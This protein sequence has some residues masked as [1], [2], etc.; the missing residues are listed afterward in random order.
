MRLGFL[1]VSYLNIR[2]FAIHGSLT[3]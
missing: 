2:L 1:W 3:A